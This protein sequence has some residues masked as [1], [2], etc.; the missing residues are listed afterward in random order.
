M[1]H[2]KFFAFLLT[3]LLLI[4]TAFSGKPVVAAET[5]DDPPVGLEVS[6]Q[7]GSSGT[8]V[9]LSFVLYKDFNGFGGLQAK[10]NGLTYDKTVFTYLRDESPLGDEGF[11]ASTGGLIYADGTNEILP[12]QTAL[13]TLYFS[14]TDQ[15]VKGE[16]Y[17]FVLNCK[18]F[19]FDGEPYSWS[20]TSFTAVFHEHAYGEPEWNWAS[21]H[22][23][24]TA[25]F[26]CVGEDDTRQVTDDDI[27]E[28]EVTPAT[29][30]GN[31]VVKYEA[32]VTFEGK[33]YET[34][35]ENVTL[36]DTAAGHAWG[37]PSYVWNKESEP[38]KCTATRVC[39]N[40]ESHVETE[41]ATAELVVIT[42]ATT[43]AEGSGEW[44]AVFE[45]E[46]FKMQ[47]ESVTIPKIPGWHINLTNKTLSATTTLDADLLYANGDVTFTVANMMVLD[48]FDEPV[49]VGC[50]VAV[51]NGDGTYTE[52]EHTLNGEEHRFAVVM[53]GAD[54]DLVLVLRGDANLDG[55]L[56]GLDM[57]KIKKHYLETSLLEGVPLAAAD[58]NGDGEADSVDILRVKKF[59]LGTQK[60]IPWDKKRN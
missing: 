43:M 17:E 10:K 42:P 23:S 29:C 6:T 28:I 14:L 24:A 5:N 56:D 3:A 19:D 59:F 48:Q 27:A 52:L 25:T 16:T 37:T 1:K 53:N 33:K 18:A 55:D 58:A 13:V 35:S 44:R 41:T 31:K 7:E 60:N 36:P 50:I 39:G 45:N 57:L 15:Y 2:K 4:Q 49:D 20:N 38:W 26:T 46:A 40:D 54:V 30:T 32:E 8:E 47:A 21:G 34:T 9:V 22:S 11:I 12:A 51:D